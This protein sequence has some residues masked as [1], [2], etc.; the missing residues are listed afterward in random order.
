MS[1]RFVACCGPLILDQ[2]HRT[3]FLLTMLETLRQT[4][5]LGHAHML[6]KE[7]SILYVHVCNIKLYFY[8][9]F[10]I[11]GWLGL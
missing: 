4:E 5:Q 2:S 9:K 6:A 8:L 10:G 3:I 7:D 11:L 1:T